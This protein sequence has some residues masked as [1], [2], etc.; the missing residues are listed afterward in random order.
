MLIFIYFILDKLTSISDT[1]SD[2]WPL[3]TSTIFDKVFMS[4]KVMLVF[5]FSMTPIGK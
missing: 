3:V 5:N 4:S 2:N 1:F